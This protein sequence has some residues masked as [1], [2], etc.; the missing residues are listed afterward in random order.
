M[1]SLKR[2]GDEM[3]EDV[4]EDN[5][6]EMEVDGS[7]SHDGSDEDAS[8]EESA[9]TG[10]DT[11]TEI[12]LA[13]RTGKSKKT[14]SRSFFGVHTKHSTYLLQLIER[15]RRALSPT[16]FGQTLTALLSTSA[17]STQPLSL[18]PS[19]ARAKNDERLEVKARKVLQG[20]RKEKEEKGRI[21]DVIGGWGGESER[22][23]R[24]VAQRG[25][26]HFSWSNQVYIHA[27]LN[28]TSVVKLFNVIQQAQNAAEEADADLKN[29]KGTG[30][31][32]LK[33]PNADDF[34]AGRQQKSK[35]R[36]KDKDNVIGRGKEGSS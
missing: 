29:L 8:G 17:P 7:S 32:T 22:A 23:L 12:A 30:K 6:S 27:D 2:K 1:S 9:N 4:V 35:G 28:S 19:V 18:K 31:A 36:G 14:L 20:E 3:E 5:R 11:D 24:K 16:P 25:G 34:G 21:R 26:E 10:T 13:Q 33:A 15:K